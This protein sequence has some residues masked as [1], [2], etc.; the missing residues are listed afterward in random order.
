MLRRAPKTDP[1][2]PLILEIMEIND[3]R[4]LDLLMQ[5]CKNQR[6]V[7]PFVGAGLSVPQKMPGWSQFLRAI[8]ARHAAD[9]PIGEL[10]ERGAYEEA[11]DELLRTAGA[12]S[13][14]NSMQEA[15]GVHKVPQE[16]R[17]AAR[18]LPAFAPGPVVTTNFDKVL[19]QAFSEAGKPF[20][21]VYWGAALTTARDA[22]F[23]DRHVL[24]KL[25]GDVEHLSERILTLTEYEVYYGSGDVDFSR[26]LPSTLRYLFQHRLVLFVGCSLR[27]DR[28][29]KVVRDSV[30][31][32][33]RHLA[34]VERPAPD[35]EFRRYRQFLENSGILPIWYPPDRHESV[36]A[37]LEYVRAA[38]DSTISAQRT[39]SR[40]PVMIT[41]LLLLLVL[42][43]GTRYV[44][45]ELAGDRVVP[46]PTG[47]APIPVTR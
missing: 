43:E 15:F 29:V 45:A 7:V 16:I 8:A 28:T 4:P 9:R 47:L 35:E 41:V 37:L 20:E 46:A 31:G 17:G 42:I 30:S 22:V 6:G 34:I 32:N 21:H 1:A 27:Y 25:H 40:Y 5:Q 14:A 11:A 2:N 13:F 19:E 24:L 33:V 36:E 44:R 18:Y 12:L 10:L 23:Y 26:P 3:S 39:K 38:A